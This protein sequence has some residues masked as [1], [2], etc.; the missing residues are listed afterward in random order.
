M[1]SLCFSFIQVG[2]V[3]LTRRADGSLHPAQVIQER[4]CEFASTEF[5]VHYVGLNRRLDQWVVRARIMALSPNS[6]AEA[7]AAT[8]TAS[9]GSTSPRQVPVLTQRISSESRLNIV[10]ENQSN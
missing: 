8:Q 4:S 7:T 5:Y 2:Q 3:Y 6:A 1:L 10:A 9:D